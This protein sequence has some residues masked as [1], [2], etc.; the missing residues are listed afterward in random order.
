MSFTQLIFY[1]FASVAVVSGFMVIMQRNVV[2]SALFLVGTFFSVAGIYVLLGAEFLAIVQLLVYAGGIMVLFLFVIMLVRL[3]QTHGKRRWPFTGIV[4]VIMVVLLV[5]ATLGL[6]VEGGRDAGTGPVEQ[7]P[8]AGNMER[9]GMSLFSDY[10]LPF[11]VASILLLVAM[12]GAIVL[13]R[14]A[15]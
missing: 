14:E 5:G 15:Y 11:E 13:A 12:V 9:I 1:V 3:D 2:H 8:E 4:G 7:A 6:M 10:I